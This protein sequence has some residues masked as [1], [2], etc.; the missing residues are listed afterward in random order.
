[1]RVKVVESE[2]ETYFTLS[3]ADTTL[4]LTSYVV[5]TQATTLPGLATNSLDIAHLSVLMSLLKKLNSRKLNQS[6]SMR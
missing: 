4:E 5:L 3:K 1:M 2:K 6:G